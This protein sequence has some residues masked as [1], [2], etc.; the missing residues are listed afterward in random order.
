M[1]GWAGLMMAALT[2]AVAAAQP[3]APTPQTYAA[4]PPHDAGPP[5]QGWGVFATTRGRTLDLQS[6]DLGWGD[7]AHAAPGDVEVGV[8]WRG[9]H[10]SAIV[11]Y[12]Q[13][14]LGARG[15][16]AEQFDPKWRGRPPHSEPGL[17][18]VSVSI[19]SR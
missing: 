2:P 4:Q 15:G 11:G 8:G 14:E 7:D 12:A 19:R 3:A 13:R 6:R 10:A 17:I 18:G 1:R 16:W 9:D 5:P